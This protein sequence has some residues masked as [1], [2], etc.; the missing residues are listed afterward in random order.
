MR[1]RTISDFFWRDPDISDLS[2]ED[3]AT[4]LY[5]LTSPSSNI[6]GVYQIVWRIASAEMGWTSEQLIVVSKRLQEKLLIDFTDDGWIFVKIWW[7]HNSSLG[8]FSPKLLV[9]AKSQCD[10]MPLMWINEF[11]VLLEKKGVDR[12]SIGY[13]YSTYRVPPNT[14][15]NCSYI[16]NTTTINQNGDLDFKGAGLSSAEIDSLKVM[17]SGQSYELAQSI[18]DEISGLKQNRSIKKN[19]ISLARGLLMKALAGEFIPAAGLLITSNR[20][21]RNLDGNKFNSSASTLDGVAK[22]LAEMRAV[23]SKK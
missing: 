10:A 20:V 11:L 13:P 14:T 23:I 2:Q 12:V 4:L 5:F 7:K 16:F 18:I 3:K 22:G 8:A 19:V 15:T 21:K 6:I 1:Q 9:K 17:L